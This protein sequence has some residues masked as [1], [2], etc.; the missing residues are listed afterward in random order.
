MPLFSERSRPLVLC[1]GD[2]D[3]DLLIAV[4]H[5]PGDAEKI[6][7]RRLARSPGGMMANTAVAL[8]RLGTP[9]RLLATVGDDAEGAFAVEAVTAEGVDTRFVKHLADTATFICV[10]LVTPRGEKSLIRVISDAYLPKPGDLGEEVMAGAGHLHL[11]FG[12]PELTEAALSM[13]AARGLS[14]SLD[15]EE[16][17]MPEDPALL[18]RVLAMSDVVIMGRAAAEAARARLGAAA[19]GRHVTVTTLGA[20]GALAET[21]EGRLMASGLEAAAV[22]TTG[23]GD[24]FAAGFLHRW[25]AGAPIERALA[26]ANVVGAL[27]AGAAGAQAALP[28][29]AEAEAVLHETETKHP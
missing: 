12:R 11:T 6:N 18:S 3:V 23:A 4:P 7:G 5:P 1:V 20:E 16:A 19:R 2:L 14:T 17:D 22:D 24:A 8:A 26:F 27:A 15:L 29:E 21:R 25:L 28:S 13:A 9:V 10:S